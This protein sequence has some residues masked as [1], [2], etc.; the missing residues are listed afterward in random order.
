MTAAL[1]PELYVSDLPTS[2]SFYRALGFQ[3]LYARLAEHFAYIERHGAELMLDE[4]RGRVWLSGP[5]A[6][7]FGRGINLQITVSDADALFAARPA[8][9]TIIMSPETRLYGRADDTITVRQFVLADPDGY[10]VR[11]SQVLPLTPTPLQ[12]TP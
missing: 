6:Q 1:V 12:A 8:S 2:L 9:A 7:P 5:L 3:I 11:F 4:P 10:L